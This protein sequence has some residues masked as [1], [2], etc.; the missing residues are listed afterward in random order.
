MGAAALF[1]L[2]AVTPEAGAA[3]ASTGP[4]AQKQA[5]KQIQKQDWQRDGKRDRQK[6]RPRGDAPG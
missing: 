3:E 6:G 2:A 5:Q 1:C 4:Q